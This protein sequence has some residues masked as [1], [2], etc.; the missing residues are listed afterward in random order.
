M[1]QSQLKLK[2]FI[3]GVIFSDNCIDTT[4]ENLINQDDVTSG[5]LREAES[6]LSRLGYYANTDTL[7]LEWKIVQQQ[8]N[9]CHPF[10]L[11]IYDSQHSDTKHMVVVKG[12]WTQGTNK[13]LIIYDPWGNCTGQKYSLDFIKLYTHDSPNRA[14][15]FVININQKKNA[16]CLSCNG[17]NVSDAFSSNEENTIESTFS[18]LNIPFIEKKINTNQI[19]N[20]NLVEVKFISPKKLKIINTETLSDINDIYEDS[21]IVDVIVN[22]QTVVRLSKFSDGQYKVVKIFENTYKKQDGKYPS[23]FLIYTQL[24]QDFIV[25]G[26]KIIP[27]YDVG[28][29]Y[30]KNTS[31]G[32]SNFRKSLQEIDIKINQNTEKVMMDTD[33]DKL[34]TILNQRENQLTPAQLRI[35]IPS[36]VQ[37]IFSNNF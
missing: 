11:T 2:R 27:Q 32:I 18:I 28:N 24:H 21:K 5:L 22:E 33:L 8:I 30:S 12:Y 15:N 36:S 10:L 14:F 20:L 3:Q 25:R 17:R 7:Q 35:A 34:K 9:N 1:R 37:R 19:D 6:I 23:Q 31:L 4:C 13:Y 29:I 26:N 16:P